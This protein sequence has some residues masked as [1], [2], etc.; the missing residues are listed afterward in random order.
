M[1][2]EA[3]LLLTG[4]PQSVW[5]DSVG[6]GVLQSVLSDPARFAA[7]QLALLGGW[8]HIAGNVGARGIAER[9]ESRW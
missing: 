7:V 1:G 6:F 5:S 9:F 2:R 8:M 4:M 3:A